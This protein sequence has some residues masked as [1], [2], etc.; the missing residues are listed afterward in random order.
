[1]SAPEHDNELDAVTRDYLAAFVAVERPSKAAAR[2]AWAEIDRRTSPAF[3]RWVAVAVLVAAAVLLALFVD[4][5]ELAAPQR[6]QPPSQAPY[7]G[8]P[9]TEGGD[10]RERD[11]ARGKHVL[12]RD[13]SKTSESP[14]PAEPPP[15][16]A[17]AAG[18]AGDA[19]GAEAVVADETGG[20]AHTRPRRSSRRDTAAPAPAGPS[21]L[22]EETAL[23]KSIQEL[24]VAGRPNDAL[25]KIAAHR[26][27]FPQGVFANEVT[28]AQAEA[29]CA[30]GRAQQSRVVA[31]TFV[32]RHPSSHLVTRAKSI[33]AG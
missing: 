27:R 19:G 17:V 2:A 32:K 9:S 8:T 31:E 5:S 23:L 10:A 12:Q 30:L 15:P 18:G 21:A 25:G 24:L 20:Q 14:G 3:G 22:A 28:V 16:P 11:D 29:L 1:M 7:E 33:C 4:W 6:D 13:A 26:K